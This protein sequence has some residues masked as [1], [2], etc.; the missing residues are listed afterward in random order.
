MK[1]LINAHYVSEK[2]KLTF[3]C[4]LSFKQPFLDQDFREICIF[5]GRKTNLIA[6][7]SGICYN[8]KIG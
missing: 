2:M 1:G 5:L 7:L 4:G 6:I 3:T 8:N